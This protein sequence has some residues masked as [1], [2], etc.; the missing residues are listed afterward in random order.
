LLVAIADFKDDKEQDNREQV[1]QKFHSVCRVS[2]A[3]SKRSDA[4]LM[5]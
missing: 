4:E 5:Q 3:G 2:Q 1:E